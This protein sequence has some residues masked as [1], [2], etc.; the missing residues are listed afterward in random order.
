VY[1]GDRGG[2]PTGVGEDRQ[3]QQDKA[4]MLM[5]ERRRR[6]T[7]RPGGKAHGGGAP[8]AR[9][10]G[11][12]EEDGEEADA[13][14]MRMR[15]LGGR[16]RSG[17]KPAA[18]RGPTTADRRGGGGQGCRQVVGRQIPGG[19]RR[20]RILGGRGQGAPRKAVV[21]EDDSGGGG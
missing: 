15:S 7:G 17:R 12:E 11:A 5:R 14:S 8:E 3:R 18:L 9:E 2:A 1:T 16:G 21:G 19:R 20:W 10:D 13:R 4:T 6:C